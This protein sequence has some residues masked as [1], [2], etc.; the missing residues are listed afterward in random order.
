MKFDRAQLLNKYKKATKSQ[1]GIKLK[2]GRM[3]VGQAVDSDNRLLWVVKGEAGTEVVYAENQH[4]IVPIIPEF[5]RVIL[6]K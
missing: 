6:K 4:A 5:K 3:V 1:G 2:D